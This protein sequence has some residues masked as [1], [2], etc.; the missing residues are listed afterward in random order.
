MPTI[1]SHIAIPLMSGTVCSRMQVSGRLVIAA[2]VASILPDADSIGFR[3]GIPYGSMFGHRGFS[4]SL[5][6]AVILGLVGL[7][8]A[9]WLRSKRITAFFIIAIAALSHGLLDALTNGGYGI[10]FFSPFSNERYF[11]PWQPIR[12]SPLSITRFLSFRGWKV[13]QSEF[14][15]IWVPVIAVSVLGIARKYVI[16]SAGYRNK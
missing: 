16:N 15:W 2:I 11:F 4:H 13:L 8:C 3:L 1:L 10:A 7:V 5:V 14:M 9:K 12:V 6:F